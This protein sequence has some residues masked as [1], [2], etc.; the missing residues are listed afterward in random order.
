[1]DGKPPQCVLNIQVDT[2]YFQCARAIQRSQPVAPDARPAVP[3]AGTI[4]AALTQDQIDGQAYD[5][6]LPA[7]QQATL[8]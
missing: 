8:Y 6:A 1:M 5:A 2:V 4:L 7:R 3:T